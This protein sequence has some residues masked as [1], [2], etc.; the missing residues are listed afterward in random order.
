MRVAPRS[1]LALAMVLAAASSTSAA[2]D[3]EVPLSPA[4]SVVFLGKESGRQAIV[5]S[6]RDPFFS[7]LTKIDAELRLAEPLPNST[8]ESRSMLLKKLFQD[9]VQD[10]TD[11]EVQAMTQYCQ[12]VFQSAQ[13]IAP[14]WIPGQWKFIKTDGSEEAQAAYTR[15]DAIVLPQGKLQ[16]VVSQ[17]ASPNTAYETAKLIAHETSH[18][19]SR[20][21]PETRDRLYRRLG[22][23]R[24]GP[25]RMGKALEPLRITNP[26]GVTLE[27]VIDVKHPLLGQFPAVMVTYSKSDRFAPEI[28]RRLFDY[29]RYDL[30][31]VEN[32]EGGPRIRGGDAGMPRAFSPKEVAGFYEK[33]GRNTGY[34]IHPDE[35]L[36]DNVA[37]LMTQNVP[38][39]PAVQNVDHGLLR[40]LA[41]ILRAGN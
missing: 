31:A 36:A 35:I 17:G 16:S 7:S 10:W 27:H 23:Y 6:E 13:Q 25:I 12:V 21:N 3:R 18:V 4:K 11:Q 9:A 38:G 14:N 40:D 5:E 2:G 32:T 15:F 29:L 19:Y 1:L 39:N 20:L 30:F 8:P 28:G 24:V 37:L 26:D 22:F 33:I 41:T 34:I